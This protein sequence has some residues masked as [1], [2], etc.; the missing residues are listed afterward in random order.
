MFLYARG[1]GPFF[2]FGSEANRR[3]GNTPGHLGF[4]QNGF[5]KITTVRLNLK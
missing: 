3:H 4:I 2:I 1:V 5:I